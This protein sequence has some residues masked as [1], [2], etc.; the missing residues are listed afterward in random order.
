[1]LNEHGINTN[2][3]VKRAGTPTGMAMISVD[4]Q[5]ENTIVVCLAAATCLTGSGCGRSQRQK[6]A[7]QQ[8]NLRE[9]AVLYGQFQASHRGQAPANEAEF[10]EF[11]R[12]AGGKGPKSAVDGAAALLPSSPR[13]GKP[14]VIV[15]GQPKTQPGPGV[16][17]IVAY[18]HDGMEGKRLVANSLG[19]IL[20]VDQTRFE[21]LTK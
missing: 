13:D 5:A 1:M 8:A 2:G 10:I 17:A 7:I 9:I 21:Q 14:Y 20:E 15:Y 16:M 6:Q 19:M 3:V 11:L 4:A 12:S 18:E